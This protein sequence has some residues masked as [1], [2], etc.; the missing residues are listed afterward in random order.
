MN[1]ELDVIHLSRNPKKGTDNEMNGKVFDANQ[2]D[3]EDVGVPK[4]VGACSPFCSDAKDIGIFVFIF[5]M[6]FALLNSA[7]VIY[8]FDPDGDIDHINI[9]Y[10]TTAFIRVFFYLAVGIK[11]GGPKKYFS[12]VII[13]DPITFPL[14]LAVYA[15]IVF[16]VSVFE[17]YP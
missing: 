1:S 9:A 12:F 10:I 14:G 2:E 7:E 3:D 5:E 11:M 15:Y 13:L 4:P 16:L 6:L 8:V 17:L